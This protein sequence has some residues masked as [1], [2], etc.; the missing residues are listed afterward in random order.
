MIPPV[1]HLVVSNRALT[2][3]ARARS[4]LRVDRRAAPGGEAVLVSGGTGVGDDPLRLN[5]S[6]LDPTRYAGSVLR[7]QLEQLLNALVN[8]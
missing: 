5:R 4:R 6:V 7:W 1:A 2:E 3:R 8:R